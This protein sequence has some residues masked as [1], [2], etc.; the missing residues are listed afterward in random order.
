MSLHVLTGKIQELVAQQLEAAQ[1]A[2]KGGVKKMQR[3]HR[4]MSSSCGHMTVLAIYAVALILG[5]VFLHRVKVFL[6]WIF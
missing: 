3:M 1:A 5:L 4:D 2:L 6:S